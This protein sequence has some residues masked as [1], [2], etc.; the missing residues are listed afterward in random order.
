[1]EMKAERSLEMSDDK[2]LEGLISIVR[3]LALTLSKVG[4]RET[5]A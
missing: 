5:L 4:V 1:M 2:N 3:T